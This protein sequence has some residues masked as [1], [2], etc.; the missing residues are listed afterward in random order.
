MGRLQTMELW[1]ICIRLFR[2]YCLNCNYGF[3][4]CLFPEFPLLN[5]PPCSTL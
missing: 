3:C 4:E 2:K 1:A 5:V